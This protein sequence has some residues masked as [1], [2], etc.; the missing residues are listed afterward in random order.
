M[1]NLL[2]AI[3]GIVAT[4]ANNSSILTK[5]PSRT[6]MFISLTSGGVMVSLIWDIRSDIRN[7]S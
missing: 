4:E 1:T 7:S 6:V 2:S 5:L 3:N